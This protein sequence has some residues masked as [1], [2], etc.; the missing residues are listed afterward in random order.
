M[1]KHHVLALC[2]ADNDL[3]ND[4]PRKSLTPTE[5]EAVLAKTAGACHVCGGRAGRSWQA[6]HVVPHRLKG[7]HSVSN[8]LPI[9]RACKMLRRSHAP[10]VQRMV[11]QLGLYARS[12]I[13]KQS[14]LGE[15]LVQMYLRRKRTNKLRQ[16][17][18]SR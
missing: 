9:C 2:K 7:P 10:E 11:L 6:D 18:D 12:E 17:S 3:R 14:E 1:K 15:R 4:A 13:N 16:K 5:R 8:Y